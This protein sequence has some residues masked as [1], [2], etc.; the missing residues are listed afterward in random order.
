MVSES[1]DGGGLLRDTHS[2][3]GL[4]GAAPEWRWSVPERVGTAGSFRNAPAVPDRSGPRPSSGTFRNG[5]LLCPG[6]TR[7]GGAGRPLS[8]QPSI[9]FSLLSITAVSLLA[10]TGQVPPTKLR[11]HGDSRHADVFFVFLFAAGAVGGASLL[12]GPPSRHT[13]PTKDREGGVE[14]FKGGSEE[15]DSHSMQVRLDESSRLLHPKA[16]NEHRG[17]CVAAPQPL[18]R[19]ILSK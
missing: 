1:P 15:T 2:G 8:P 16:A 7:R 17:F 19:T 18:C 14:G 5:V 10:S 4:S 13:N 3:A 9:G 6:V 12:C 11:L